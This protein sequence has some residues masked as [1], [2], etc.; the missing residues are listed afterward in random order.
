MDH[1]AQ[2]NPLTSNLYARMEKFRS[3]VGFF[4]SEP[5]SGVMWTCRRIYDSGT[6][7]EKGYMTY[8]GP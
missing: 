6:V 1:S 5:F 8:V 3:G 7:I 2:A 4:L